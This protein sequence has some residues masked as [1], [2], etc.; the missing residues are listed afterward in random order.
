[1]HL[2]TVVGRLL[3]DPEVRYFLSGTSVVRLFVLAKQRWAT[4]FGEVNTSTTRFRILAYG[5]AIKE[6]ALKLRKGDSVF[7]QG[8]LSSSSESSNLYELVA[9]FIVRI[10]A[11][12]PLLPP[13]RS[14]DQYQPEVNLAS[15]TA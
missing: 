1:M 5:D 9:D 13:T 10:P 12:H 4:P 7:V 14:A 11:S 6:I 15:E 8:R 2:I 3:T